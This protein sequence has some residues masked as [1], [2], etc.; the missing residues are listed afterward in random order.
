M[1]GDAMCC[2][3]CDA[4]HGD[5][6]TI[7]DASTTRPGRAGQ[8]PAVMHTTF[9]SC[10]SCGEVSSIG[11]VGTSAS[12]GMA[13][14]GTVRSGLDWGGPVGDCRHP[15]HATVG[16]AWLGSMA[17]RRC[18]RCGGG[19]RLARREEHGLRIMTASAPSMR[20]GRWA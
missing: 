11:R 6:Q 5:W 15:T 14:G 10:V 8:P 16:A 3:R 18:A 1:S 9:A 17:E 7:R 19:W 12:R 4:K 13:P 20:P 2:W